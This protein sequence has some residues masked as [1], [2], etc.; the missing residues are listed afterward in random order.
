[1]RSWILHLLHHLFEAEACGF[2][3]R[4]KFL[5]GLQEITNVCLCLSDTQGSYT[6]HQYGNAP[7]DF[8]NVLQ[9]DYSLIKASGYFSLNNVKEPS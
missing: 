6:N 2:H 7:Q 8:L 9:N 3:A 5:E 1:M 4:R